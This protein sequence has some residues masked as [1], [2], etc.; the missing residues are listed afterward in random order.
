[1][2]NVGQTEAV[3]KNDFIHNMTTI[4]SAY[5]GNNKVSADELPK[6]LRQISDALLTSM[7]GSAGAAIMLPQMSNELP[8]ETAVSADLTVTSEIENEQIEAVSEED[9]EE[10]TS[11]SKVDF[12]RMN[13]PTVPAVPITESI[14]ANTVVCLFDGVEKKSLKRYIRANFGMEAEEY[15]AYWKLPAEYPL[16]AP[17]YS[18]EKRRVAKDQGLG[19]AKV[20]KTPR[21]AR[22]VDERTASVG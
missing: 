9:A 21:A 8:G 17:S 22:T 18:A 1:M 14:K 20:T 19:T 11:T 15:R 6:L 10:V 5:L 4:A 3:S 16:V 12:R 7:N 13:L 2:N